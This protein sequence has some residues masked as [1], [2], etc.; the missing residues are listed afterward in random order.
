MPIGSK[1]LREDFLADHFEKSMWIRDP[2]QWRLSFSLAE[3]EFVYSFNNTQF[4]VYGIFKL[5][6]LEVFSQD[7]TV[8]DCICSYFLKTVL[9]W[10]IK[11]T[12][13]DYWKPERLVLCVDICFQRLIE[14]TRNG[15]CPN[16]FVRKNNMFM[17]KIEEWQLDYIA[18]KLSELHNEGWR[19]LLRCHSLQHLKRA[20]ENV[21]LKYTSTTSSFFI[22][23]PEED[24]KCLR[25][26]IR[27]E[28]KLQVEAYMYVDCVLFSEILT[29]KPKLPNE[30]VLETELRKS[31]TLEIQRKFDALDLGILRLRRFHD[32]CQLA[33]IYLNIWLTKTE[34][35]VVIHAF[36]KHLATYILLVILI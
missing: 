4:L 5:L 33:L 27:S 12:P 25:S 20:L 7:S 28:D 30:V 26:S 22:S 24:F 6:N 11:E 32:L 9:F 35:E 21:R 19:C 13:S 36:E 31:L 18:V 2:L 3:K 8:K 23:N 10:T 14:W 1:K 16:Y 34:L 29:R 15:F 17:G